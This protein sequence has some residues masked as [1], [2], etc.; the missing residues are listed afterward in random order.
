MKLYRNFTSQEEI[1]YQY[2]V[3]V[4]EPD[5]QSYVEMFIGGS[6]KARK[7]LDCILDVRFG[8]TV[9]ETVDIFP[10][11]Q[12]DAP[13][14]VYIHG[15]YWHSLS[16]KEFSVVATGPNAHGFTV[17]LPNYSLC[18]KVTITEITRQNR[19]FIAWLYRNARKF[20][21]N[22]ERIFVCGHS[23]GG[24]QV[25]MLAATDWPGE[26]GLPENIIKGGIPISGLFDLFPFRYSWLQPK[27]QLS[28][29]VIQQQSPLF[30]IPAK[31][32]PLLISVGE[33]ESAEFHRQAADYLTAWR[34]QNLY[35]ELFVQPN[36]N[37]FTSIEGLIDA[38]STFCQSMIDFTKECEIQ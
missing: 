1:D 4:T 6:E 35:G 11:K 15:G 27:L 13:I 38:N 3:A 36:K 34:A 17:V 9:D 14:I 7:E 25:G 29:E 2:N 23:A 22:P 16:S 8:P 26:Y 12:P 30:N 37:H 28:S 33:K 21:G 32:P 5:I 31:G 24:H 19:A 20:N 18:P 10:A